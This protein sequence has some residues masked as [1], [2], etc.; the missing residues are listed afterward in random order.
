M[1]VRNP[2]HEATRELPPSGLLCKAQTPGTAT[3]RPFPLHPLDPPHRGPWSEL[4]SARRI[5]PRLGP[6][7]RPGAQALRGSEC[8]WVRPH[9]R[10]DCVIYFFHQVYQGPNCDKQKRIP[11]LK[12]LQFCGRQ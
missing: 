10:S 8:L 3:T 9:A 2:N 6:K 4:W 5:L 12:C 7:C 1:I 11:V